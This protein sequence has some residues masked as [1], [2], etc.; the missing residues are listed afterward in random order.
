[1]E[2]INRDKVLDDMLYIM[3]GTGYQ[4]N[5]MSV[6]KM[7]DEVDPIHAMGACYCHECKFS[8][9][10]EYDFQKYLR[11]Q[12]DEEYERCVQPNEFCSRGK[13]KEKD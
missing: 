12:E 9:P 8:N 1:M 2:L 3:C 6:I 4:S 10:S 7:A 13:R 5:A 11:C